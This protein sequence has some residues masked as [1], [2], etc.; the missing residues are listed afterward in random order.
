MRTV[1]CIELNNG[2]HGAPYDAVASGEVRVA[3]ENRAYSLFTVHYSLFVIHCSLF[4]ITPHNVYYVKYGIWREKGLTFS[5]YNVSVRYLELSC[6]RRY[7]STV[8]SYVS[9]PCFN[10]ALI[11]LN[12]FLYV[13]PGAVF[14]ACGG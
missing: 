12:T 11:T 9:C 5:L 7:A 1:K 3:R 6:L 4:T 10:I 2:A 8:D 14:S 13:L